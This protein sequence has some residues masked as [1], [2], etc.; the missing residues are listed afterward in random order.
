MGIFGTKKQTPPPHPRREPRYNIPLTA[1]SVAR[2]EERRV[3]KE[4]L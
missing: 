3:G 2:S 4:C 1:D